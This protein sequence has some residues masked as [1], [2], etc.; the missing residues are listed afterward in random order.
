MLSACQTGIGKFKYGEGLLSLSRAFAYAGTKSIVAT[1]WSVADLQTSE[2]VQLFYAA[3]EQ[4]MNKAQAL[5][6]AKL[7]YLK[8]C[9]NQTLAHPYY[10]AALILNGDTSEIIVPTNSKKWKWLVAFLIASFLLVVLF[11]T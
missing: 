8:A 9:K 3:F 5:R 4:K 6:A 1:L 2:L 10:W 11:K 7:Q